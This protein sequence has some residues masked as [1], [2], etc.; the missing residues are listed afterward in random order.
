LKNYNFTIKHLIK[1]NKNLNI[2]NNEAYFEHYDYNETVINIQ[3]HINC[4]KNN[5]KAPIYIDERFLKY[6]ILTNNIDLLYY[7]LKNGYKFETFTDTSLASNNLQILKFIILHGSK[8]N[9]ITYICSATNGNLDCLKYLHENNGNL[10]DED[11]LL[12]AVEN[13]Y[14]DCVKYLIKLGYHSNESHCLTAVYNDN[15]E[16]LRCLREN[17]CTWNINDCV[18]AILDNIKEECDYDGEYGGM[19]LSEPECQSYIEKSIDFVNLNISI[20]DIAMQKFEEEHEKENRIIANL[21]H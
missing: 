14:L 2:I 5:K 19:Y 9:A 4:Q 6:A 10:Y 16:C 18:S 3:T 13:N 8:I 15:L 17:S 7:A 11:L 12:V 21:E 20:Y 1:L